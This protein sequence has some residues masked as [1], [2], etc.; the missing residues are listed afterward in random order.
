[1]YEIMVASHTS[2]VNRQGQ[3]DTA[4]QEY[5]LDLLGFRGILTLHKVVCQ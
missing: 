2:C 4:H 5:S 1:M 3:P